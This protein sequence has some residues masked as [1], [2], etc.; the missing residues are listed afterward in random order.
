MEPI[1]LLLAPKAFSWKAATFTRCS[2]AFTVLGRPW[3]RRRGGDV[4]EETPAVNALIDI[5]SQ[6]V[7]VVDRELAIQGTHGAVASEYYSIAK[8]VP[9]WLWPARRRL[10]RQALDSVD[11]ALRLNQPDPSGLRGIR[12][13]ILLHLGAPAAAV[14]DYEEMLRLRIESGEGISEAEVE[15]GMGYLWAGRVRKAEQ[16][17]ESGVER[18]QQ[19]R[20]SGFTVRAL[21]KL[22][23]FYRV[24]LRWPR[25][26]QVLA[27]AHGLA[28]RLGLQ[29]PDRPDRA[30]GVGGG[31]KS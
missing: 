17:L 27:E 18:L 26:R 23:L 2:L 7:A 10:F 6:G 29:V 16:L 24:T 19:E 14:R 15:L 3:A 13:S 1:A 8:R 25:S 30:V 20:P 11:L 5:R 28:T 31:W 9:L 12:G 21:R 4:V 22:S